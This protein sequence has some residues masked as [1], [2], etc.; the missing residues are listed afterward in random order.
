MVACAGGIGLVRVW[1]LTDGRPVGEPIRV[2]DG[3][4]FDDHVHAVALG[5][6]PDGTP[7][8]VSVGSKGW[9]R[10]WRLADAHALVPPLDLSRP[11]TGVAMHGN[12]IISA[13]GPDIAV[14][15]LA[16]PRSTG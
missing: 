3:R 13:E 10:V 6:L 2:H 7:V 1:R 9:V 5:E 11:V 16:E 8:V 14:H 15:Q 12:R 4:V